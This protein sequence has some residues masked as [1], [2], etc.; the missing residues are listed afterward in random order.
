MCANAV[1]ANGFS[2]SARKAQAAAFQAVYAL[3]SQSLVNDCLPPLFHDDSWA[4]VRRQSAVAAE[5]PRVEDPISFWKSCIEVS[6]SEKVRSDLTMA[7]FTPVK[8]PLDVI[9]DLF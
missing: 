6:A 8:L 2:V 1:I 4:E 3:H 7:L 9:L 5:L